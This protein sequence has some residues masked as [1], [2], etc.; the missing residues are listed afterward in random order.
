MFRPF[1]F[2]VGFVAG[3]L[4]LGTAWMLAPYGVS[5]PLLYFSA[6]VVGSFTVCH[7]FGRDW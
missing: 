1:Q 4:V 7:V 5:A 3:V 6:I 2:H